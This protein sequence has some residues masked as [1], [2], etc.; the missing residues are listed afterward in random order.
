MRSP[1]RLSIFVSLF[2][3]AALIFAA[4]A[5]ASAPQFHSVTS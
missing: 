1:L 4:T 2:A 5:P 3:V